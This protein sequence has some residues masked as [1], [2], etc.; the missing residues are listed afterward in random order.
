MWSVNVL[1]SA[2]DEGRLL[3]V[4][5]ALADKHGGS[6]T[7][8]VSGRGHQSWVFTSEAAA[9]AFAHEADETCPDAVVIEPEQEK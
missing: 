3:P 7:L 5:D 8:G 6:G 9:Y 4:L 2:E 1:F